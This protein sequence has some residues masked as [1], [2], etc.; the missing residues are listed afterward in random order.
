MAVNVYDILNAARSEAGY[1]DRIPEINQDNLA[2]LS[3]L[4]PTELN[5]FIGVIAKIVKQ[6]VYDTTFDSSDNPFAEFYQE[7]LPVGASVEDLYVDL[8]TGDVPKWNDDGS[9][10]LSRKLPTVAELYHNENYEMQ[11]KV[12]TSFAQMKSAFLTEGGVNSLINRIKGTLNSSA[13]YDLFLECL[14]LLATAFNHGAYTYRVGFD[15]TTEA[16]I[17]RLLRDIKN[18]AKDFTFMNNKYNYFGFNTKAKESD[19]V[20]ITKPDVVS[21][22]DVDYLAGVFNMSKAEIKDR[23]I[24]I[25]DGYGF[26]GYINTIDDGGGNE[27]TIE[28]FMIIMDKRLLRIFPTLMEGSSIYNPASL[29]DNTFLTLM[30]IF[31]YSL[32]MNAIVYCA[33]PENRRNRGAV[34]SLR[35]GVAFGIYVDPNIANVKVSSNLVFDEDINR[36]I[37]VSLA[38][39]ITME[40]AINTD[41]EVYSV[42]VVPEESGYTAMAEFPNGDGSMVTI[43]DELVAG[44]PYTLSIKNRTLAPDEDFSKFYFFGLNAKI[45]GGRKSDEKK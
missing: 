42:T 14:R 5:D 41:G 38:N 6:Y 10:A 44:R 31:S 2:N 20:I 43:N 4:A 25:P 45:S 30:Y 33:I 27:L 8:I 34:K 19:I 24:Y 13:Q 22:I 28:P 11:Y 18:T 15:Y 9:Y 35:D 39:D 40:S 36:Y 17:Q 3:Q 26:D 37:P 1:E 12:S 21:H 29:V 32:F 23:I 16:E 7:K